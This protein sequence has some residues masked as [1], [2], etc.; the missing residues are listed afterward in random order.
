MLGKQFGKWTVLFQTSAPNNRRGRFYQCRC[1][2]GTTKSV[3]AY[4]LIHSKSTKCEECR[5]KGV[6]NIGDVFGHWIVLEIC[7]ERTAWGA[8]KYLCQCKCKI[9]KKIA[10]GD[11]RSGAS[12]QCISCHISA[13]NKKH[14]LAK[15][16]T[17]KIWV[18]IRDRCK[19][20]NRKDFKHYGGRGISLHESWNNYEN[21]LK[22]M[23][24]RPKGLEIDRI[25]V[26]GNYE[27]GNCRWVTRK[28]NVN[29]RRCSNKKKNR[30]QKFHGC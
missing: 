29:N 11:L 7:E 17:W 22:D 9:L 24:E 21:F 14:G 6:I 20:A 30:N 13:K 28:E 25:D 5:R 19:N 18:G 4:N 27:P 26:N 2:C 15:T 8:R 12:T 16:P 1:E 3:S 10:V 23:G